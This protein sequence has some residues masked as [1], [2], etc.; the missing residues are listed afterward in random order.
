MDTLKSTDMP[1]Y[2]GHFHLMDTCL[3]LKLLT[4]LN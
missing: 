1:M 4:E 3:T 2:M